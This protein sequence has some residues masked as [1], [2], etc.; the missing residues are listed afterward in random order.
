MKKAVL[1]AVL[2]CALLVAPSALRELKWAEE[3]GSLTVV[4]TVVLLGLSMADPLAD[5]LASLSVLV[6]MSAAG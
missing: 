5:L 3:W 4:R 1:R 6:W 2:R